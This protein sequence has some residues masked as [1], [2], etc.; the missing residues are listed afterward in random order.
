MAALSAAVF[1]IIWGGLVLVSWLRCQ[2]WGGLT[3]RTDRECLMKLA[4]RNADRSRIPVAIASYKGYHR[5]CN[6]SITWAGR[7]GQGFF[8]E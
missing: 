3:V 2:G 1:V 7:M 4:E 6:S 8:I 5:F